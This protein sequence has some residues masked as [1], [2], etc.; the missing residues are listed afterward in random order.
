VGYLASSAE[1]YPAMIHD[2]RVADDKEGRMCMK[3]TKKYM[4]RIVFLFSLTVFVLMV[5][6]V[7]GC[8]KSTYPPTPPPPPPTLNPVADAFTQSNETDLAHN[9]NPLKIRNLTIQVAQKRLF[10]RMYV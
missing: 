4:K 1:D 6:L 2:H 5:L 3:M 7:A 9:S 10:T 8:G